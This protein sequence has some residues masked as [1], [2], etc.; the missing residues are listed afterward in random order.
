M[1]DDFTKFFLVEFGF[2]ADSGQRLLTLVKVY[3]VGKI[4]IRENVT[5]KNEN[6]FGGEFGLGMPERTGST[7]IWRLVDED[8]FGDEVD[9]G[10]NAG[11]R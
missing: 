5:M 11:W 8:D 6:G 7:E 3:D 1:H 9:N 10:L 2:D 4:D